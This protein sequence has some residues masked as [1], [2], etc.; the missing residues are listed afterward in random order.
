MAIRERELDT[1]YNVQIRY[2]IM[3]PAMLGLGQW[4]E[5]CNRT[6]LGSPI[7]TI[8]GSPIRHPAKIIDVLF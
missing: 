8:L 7:R 6:M 2:C 1:Q 5:Q 3:H 4:L